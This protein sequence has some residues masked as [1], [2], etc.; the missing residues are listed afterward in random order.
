[1]S[2]NQ[3][4]EM[5][6][7]RSRVLAGLP[8]EGRP[9][10]QFS[11]TGTGTFREGFV[12][13]FNPPDDDSWVGNFQP[14]ISSLYRVLE[15][16]AEEAI[17]VVAGGQGYVVNERTGALIFEYGGD[18]DFVERPAGIGMTILGDLVGFSAYRDGGLVWTSRR[19]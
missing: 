8:G 2:L 10:R 14:G 13:E 9:P 1:M 17:L 19:I 6:P 11:V 4:I 15:E 5:E 16:P 3:R 18:I 7:K 12:V